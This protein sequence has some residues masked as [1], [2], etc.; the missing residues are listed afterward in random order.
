MTN[1]RM[2]PF[3]GLRP[4]GEEEDY[5]FFGR[6]AQTTDLLELLRAQRFLAV[7]GSS[8]SGKSSLVR[9]GMLP[10]LYGG[11]MAG[12][13]S[14]WETVVLRPG[15]D[16]LLNLAE[17]MVT[18]ELYDPEDPEAPLQIR[19]TLSRSRQGLVQAVQFSEMSPASNLL[20]VVDQFE[21]LFRFRGTSEEH[22]ER[23]T[24]FV[25]LLLNAAKT[26]E[27]SI[28]VVITMRSDYI[29]D[30]SHLPGLAEAVNDGK[31][32]IPKLTRDQRRDAI[33]MPAAVGG[34]SISESLVQQLLNDVGDDADQL[35]ILQH[36][37][38][39][40]WDFWERDHA[41]G[42]PVA[43]R[44]YDAVGGMANAL[45]NHADEVYHELPG[46]ESREL[47]RRIFQAI[48]ERGGDERG[49]RRP[50][51]MDRLC[52]IVDGAPEDVKLVLD[53][54]RRVGRT[55]VMPTEGMELTGETVVDISHE[56]LMR[57]WRRLSHWVEEESQNARI[58]TR[59]AET[60][61]LYEQELAG[62]YR[63]P[64]LAIALAWREHSEPSEAWAKRYRKGFR[65]A[66][67]FL[68]E[69]YE[70]TRAEEIAG[71]EARQ[72]ELEQAKLVARLQARAKKRLSVLLGC[73]A[74]A[75]IASVVMYF[76]SLEQRRIAEENRLAAVSNAQKSEL[77]AEAA[78]ASEAEAQKQAQI[79]EVNAER[80]DQ[81]AQ[82]A[83]VAR[84]LADRQASDAEDARQEARRSLYFSQIYKAQNEPD[85]R[86]QFSVKRQ[87]VK[88]W[89][90][91]PGQEDL[92]G[93]EWYYFA[94]RP[95]WIKQVYK[96]PFGVYV[97]ITFEMS[98]EAFYL[99]RTGNVIEKRERVSGDVIGQVVLDFSCASIAALPEKNRLAVLGH[100]AVVRVMSTE[101]GVIEKEYYPLQGETE[102]LFST[103]QLTNQG[104]SLYLANS[105]NAFLINLLDDTVEPI[106]TL[107]VKLTDLT[108]NKAKFASSVMN[109]SG[110][111]LVAPHD[112]GK[113]LEYDFE[114]QKWIEVSTMEDVQMISWSHDDSKLL[115]GHAEN[116]I[117]VLAAEDFSTL[118]E[119]EIENV[120]NIRMLVW[121]PTGEN[122]LL[123]DDV[124]KQFGIAFGD[125]PVITTLPQ[126]E[127]PIWGYE[128]VPQTEE[129]V[130]VCSNKEIYLADNPFK[131]S[132][133]TALDQIS[134]SNSGYQK[135]IFTKDGKSVI[136][137][138][139]DGV[140]VFDRKTGELLKTIDETQFM[141]I[142]PTK[143]E[144]KLV[145]GRTGY[146]VRIIDMETWEEVGQIQLQSIASA[147]W[148]PDGNQLAIGRRAL[149]STLEN[150][151]VSVF[152]VSDPVNI[153]LV[154]EVNVPGEISSIAWNSSGDRLAAGG[155]VEVVSNERVFFVDSTSFEVL[156][157]AGGLNQNIS[158]LHFIPNTNT[159]IASGPNGLD[160]FVFE[161]NPPMVRSKDY[162]R[163][164]LVHLDV[165]KDGKRV[166]ARGSSSGDVKIYDVETLEEVLTFKHDEGYVYA[167]WDESCEVITA[168]TQTMEITNYDAGDGY[169]RLGGTLAGRW[170]RDASVSSEWRNDQAESAINYYIEIDEWEAAER[171]C[172]DF[173]KTYPVA[174]PLQTNWWLSPLVNA[175]IDDQTPLEENPDVFS[176]GVQASFKENW[177]QVTKD[178]DGTLEVTDWFGRQ[179]QNSIYA[180]CRIYAPEREAYG[181]FLSS[182]DYHKLWING[183]EVDY[184]LAA[185]PVVVDS[186]FLMVDLEKGWNTCL[187]KVNQLEGEY[188]LQ[189]RVT[190]Q[191]NEIVRGL[192]QE[193]NYKAANKLLA[194]ELVAAPDNDHLRY[195]RAGINRF[196]DEADLALEDINALL[197]K[198]PSSEL[199]RWKADLL[200][201]VSKREDAIEV[202]NG[203]TQS[204][205]Q[206]INALFQL[207][208]LHRR[209]NREK[210]EGIYLRAIRES[211]FDEKVV[212]RAM[213][214]METRHLLRSAESGGSHWRF[215]I[216]EPLSQ[217]WATV[218][219]DDSDW[220]AVTNGSMKP[221]GGV[222]TYAEEL[223]ARTEFHLES[224][225]QGA[226][227]MTT[228][229]GA[230]PIRA[231][232]NGVPVFQMK[233][234]NR[235]SMLGPMARGALREGRNVFSLV[236]LNRSSGSNTLTPNIR[237]Y[238]V[239]R[240][241]AFSTLFQPLVESLEPS[242][243]KAKWLQWLEAYHLVNLEP[244]RSLDLIR[245]RIEGK[246]GR[247]A[248]DLNLPP[249]QML[250]GQTSE[251]TSSYVATQEY[252][253]AQEGGLLSITGDLTGF[254][255]ASMFMNLDET[256]NKNKLEF[257]AEVNKPN[258]PLYFHAELALRENRL[259]ELETMINPLGRIHHDDDKLSQI[260]DIY[261][262]SKVYSGDY[263]EALI[264][265]RQLYH[266]VVSGLAETRSSY[267]GNPSYPGDLTN[268]ALRLSRSHE[269]IRATEADRDTLGATAFA[270]RAYAKMHLV[271]KFD[272][273][274]EE[275]LAKEYLT[276]LLEEYKQRRG[277]LEPTIFLRRLDAELLWLICTLD[278][279]SVADSDLIEQIVLMVNRYRDSN[280]A[281]WK[282][283]EVVDA[284]TESGGEIFAA[285]PGT[286]RATGEIPDTDR[287]TIRIQ[288]VQPRIVAL[289]IG[290]LADFE[291]LWGGPGRNENGN[292]HTTAIRV[293][294]DRANEAEIEVDLVEFSVSYGQPN[295][296]LLGIARQNG[297]AWGINQQQAADH[298]LVVN[299]REELVLDPGEE[300][301]VRLGFEDARW[302][303]LLPSRVSIRTNDGDGLVSVPEYLFRDSIAPMDLSTIS[304]LV[305]Y[306]LGKYAEA[307]RYVMRTA[308]EQNLNLYALILLANLEKR[309]G[310][311]VAAGQ[312]YSK[313]EE[314]GL[315]WAAGEQFINQLFGE[316]LTE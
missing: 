306:R 115:V 284:K 282:L 147:A 67:E 248:I 274:G 237:L 128:W 188:G 187:L 213:R 189:L 111:R 276:S 100:D 43:L 231:F 130:I 214:E 62:V 279:K 135:V 58:Y 263:D 7:V 5:L 10:A 271:F 41:E 11:T 106:N 75:F 250:T 240:R 198:G 172:E 139:F 268:H 126:M 275:A 191:T 297:Q 45:S 105:K 184:S 36:A 163:G 286:V 161:V 244:S 21:E 28:Y 258:F 96:Q 23:A 288:P 224:I 265:M 133:S 307:K 40:I 4:F 294:R 208:A 150:T 201:R 88:N 14:D 102:T 15:G 167:T 66:I 92:R 69:S 179:K 206:S 55:F 1:S 17:A 296:I 60:A 238:V 138:S 143:D 235:T 64:D 243:D 247:S 29:G 37:L 259:D 108:V 52:R 97:P 293:F 252:V 215:S 94:S 91:R 229:S 299:F 272:L 225:P 124:G 295:I 281:K 226:M 256:F 233:S 164:G 82:A 72:R 70:T 33:M 73:I 19:A 217:S 273:F 51:R 200:E 109:Y 219:F 173:Y 155:F 182:D 195:Q 223:W 112:D 125:S 141:L 142:K 176:N 38:M 171:L 169:R 30:C 270:T 251:A 245:K 232:L 2:N 79:A 285:E 118:N 312:W 204:N 114:S 148:S 3:P 157:T 122:I 197:A 242:R 74:L 80:A 280:I 134:I 127:L 262:L 180:L 136:T 63:D 87:F 49:I 254:M 35:P 113:L 158:D 313:I 177:W 83:D 190:G 78:A 302:K 16:P 104:Q 120:E 300:L 303:K 71:E 99:L 46:D 283:A 116:K 56:S 181:I 159:V 6:E 27:R 186:D 310:D 47:T 218:D 196:T 253:R 210:A 53:A 77:L 42:E 261:L 68:D 144:K 301:T 13:G 241:K 292:V 89:G 166:L 101:S 117:S 8:G 287:Y 257:L 145:L 228:D 174:S 121:D 149:A 65:K 183:S 291:L 160:A 216:T 277:E 264:V 211:K 146:V 132:A 246:T 255:V 212:L 153:G 151:V 103:F 178:L 123:T 249:I 205:V 48:T 39:R 260:P 44:H 95:D 234:F 222:G 110:S 239:D 12:V 175:G 76:D 61:E 194:D 290:L 119:I 203:A 309:T 20:I 308:E 267:F 316:Y 34:G 304:A 107:G 140:Q 81:Q 18:A 202:L 137:S 9:A 85:E 170:E 59:L 305:L 57:V 54:Y 185:R 221:L 266:K 209:D 236:Y 314:G 31:Y 298:K 289:E 220:G 165:S 93:W 86:E 32:L 207:A 154:G 25:K 230:V 311:L 129:L 22:E 278:E 98:A 227:F 156:A 269:I 131:D 50:T 193:G 152:D 90:P 199:S 84:R 24:E 162:Q 168:V 26:E 315:K 192:I